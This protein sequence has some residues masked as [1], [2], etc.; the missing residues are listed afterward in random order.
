MGGQNLVAGLGTPSGVRQTPRP[1][2][3]LWGPSWA[4][5]PHWCLHHLPGCR[6]ERGCGSACRAD[7]MQALGGSGPSHPP[8][9]PQRQDQGRAER[10]GGVWALWEALHEAI[11][12]LG[13]GFHGPISTA[14]ST[15]RESLL[16]HPQMEQLTLRIPRPDPPQGTS[17]G[18]Y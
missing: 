17:K 8:S 9:S 13:R 12:G 7:R 1:H 11:T 5:G 3:E 4:L 14:V 10:S 18:F 16:S 6:W 15:L 2:L